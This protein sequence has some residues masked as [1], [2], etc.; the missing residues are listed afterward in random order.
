[1]WFW[2]ADAGAKLATMLM[3]RADDGGNSGFTGKSTK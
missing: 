1:V 2:R 3:H